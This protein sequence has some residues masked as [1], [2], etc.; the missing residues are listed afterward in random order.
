MMDRFFSAQY[1]NRGSRY[2]DA[3]LAGALGAVL[4]LTVLHVV[5]VAGGYGHGSGAV[6]GRVVAV[7]EL[8]MVA[9]AAAWIPGVRRALAPLRRWTA[10]HR[11]A[12]AAAAAWRNLISDLPKAVIRIAGI[13]AIA[14]VPAEIYGVSA[15]HL[16]WVSVF[17]AAA[18]ITLAVAGGA[19]L[20]YLILE[21]ALRPVAIEIAERLPRGLDRSQ[22]VS[23]SAKL[24]LLPPVLTLYTAL[25]V[26]GVTR[27]SFGTG[28]RIAVGFGAAIVVSSTVALGATV[29]LRQSLVDPV[30]A[31]ID[32]TDRVRAGN[33]DASVTPVA[34][35]ELGVLTHR[36]NHMLEGLR[37]REQLRDLTREQADELRESR[38]R[39]VTAADAERRRLERDL[40]DGAQQHLVLLNLKLG[41]AERLL[42]TDPAKAAGMHQE[43]RADVERALTEL[44]NLAHGIYPASLENDG[45][46]AA[47]R[48]ALERSAI[49]ATLDLD[50]AGRYGPELEAAVYFCCLEAL[51]N[52]AKHAGDGAHATIRLAEGDGTLAFNVTDDGAGFE[53]SAVTASAGL[54]NMKD[55]IGAVGGAVAITSARGKGTKVT[56]TIPVRPQT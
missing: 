23:M 52:A 42:S 37:E 44:R 5:L 21:R 27:D 18:A 2:V 11:D 38:I 6:V 54:Q 10:G 36:F 14:S 46:P 48:E 20:V 40:H 35:D 17:A 43:L 19:V 3:L 34:E 12:D 51:Q 13:I 50:G 16:T 53:P 49:P 33:L 31:L 26:A 8:C 47:L 55:R 22:G 25:L 32:A 9:G 41:M 28:G 56:G 7:A 39:I 1:E 4:V 45:L 15:L 30:N 29:L 24:L